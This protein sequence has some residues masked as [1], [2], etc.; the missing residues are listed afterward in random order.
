MKSILELIADIPTNAVLRLEAKTLEK[1]VAE[2]QK[3]CA[4]LESLVSSLKQELATKTVAAD[5]IE[6]RGA[7]FKRS[8]KGGYY[9]DVLCRKCRQP[10][11]SFVGEH[12][13]MCK[14]CD[15]AVNFSGADLARIM[16]ELSRL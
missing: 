15:I 2:L 9:D 10:M 3:R 6:H 4:E 13:Y 16:Q 8:P 1:Q 11:V 14:P 7:V 5:F 12:P